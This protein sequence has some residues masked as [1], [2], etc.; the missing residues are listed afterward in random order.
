MLNGNGGG[1]G[2][3]GEGGGEKK[4][5]FF[6]KIKDAGKSVFGKIKGAFSGG[7]KSEDKREQKQGWLSRQYNKAK[8]M[9]TG[10]K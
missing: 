3:G 8:K 7:D 10:G 4:K 6:Q 1:G 2:G 5:G 9:F